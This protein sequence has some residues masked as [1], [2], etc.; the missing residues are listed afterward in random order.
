MIFSQCW[1]CEGT[2]WALPAFSTALGF[3]EGP[4]SD[5]L[6]VAQMLHSEGALMKDCVLVPVQNPDV[7]PESSQ[8]GV[9]LKAKQDPGSL[10]FM[11]AKA[12]F[13]SLLLLNL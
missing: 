8:P 5:S 3:S 7:L 9:N 10:L 11:N 12:S 2:H 1:G 4:L 6:P 13:K